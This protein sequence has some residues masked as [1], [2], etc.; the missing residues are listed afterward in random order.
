MP[1]VDAALIADMFDRHAAALALYAAQWTAA[2]DDCVHRIAGS[3]GLRVHG[4]RAPERGGQDDQR[5]A[6]VPYI[7]NG[8][9]RRT[10]RIVR[11]SINRRCS[12]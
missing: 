2:A 6:H 5:R 12:L 10:A 11:S 1:P 7:G 8:G 4:R 3:S 9:R